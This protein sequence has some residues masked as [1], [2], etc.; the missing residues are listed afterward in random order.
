VAARF[1][2]VVFQMA[3][4]VDESCAYFI[5]FLISSS[6]VLFARFSLLQGESKVITLRGSVLFMQF[7]LAM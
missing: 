2:G 5:L 4:I 3:V 1:H 7:E 6:D